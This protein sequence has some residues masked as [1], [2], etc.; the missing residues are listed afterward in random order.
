MAAD[1]FGRRMHDDVGAELDRSAEIGR[2]KGV[3]DQQR[4]FCVM[5]DRGD[6]R[7]IQHFEPGIADRLADEEFR[8]RLD[9][10]PER[11][12][13]A[14]FHEGRG[15]AEARQ[16]V[17]QQIDGAAIERAR[18]HDVVTGVE[19]RRDGQMQRGHAARGAD[20]TDTAFQRREPLFQHA[21]GGVGDARIDVAGALQVEQ[22]RRMIGILE[23]VGRGLIDRH[24][25]GAGRGI[26]M[27]ARMQAQGLEGR[28]FWRGHAWP[29]WSVGDGGPCATKTPA[30]SAH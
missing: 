3:V 28:R 11:I 26:R 8:I 13:I 7:D 2:G 9:R 17:R 23:H 30:T 1:P 10:L 12:E 22:R 20:R 6:L 15:D 24:R 16:R 21:G 18:R 25:A 4:N 19:Q 29:R 27:L 14:R 5:R